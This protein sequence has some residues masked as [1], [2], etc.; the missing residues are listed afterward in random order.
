MP[1]IPDVV[2]LATIQSAQ[3]GNPMRNRVLH[4][5]TD[6]GDYNSIVTSAPTGTWVCKLYDAGSLWQ[7]QAAGMVEML[8]VRRDYVPSVILGSTTS[9]KITVDEAWSIRNNGFVTCRGKVHWNANELSDTYGKISVTLPYPPIQPG[10]VGAFL[11]Y[12]ASLNT[13][14]GGS[15]V[16]Q[17]DGTMTAIASRHP[18]IGTTGSG[19]FDEFHGIADTLDWTVGYRTGTLT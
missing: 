12:D 1:W 11:A 7:K 6:A 2:S 9:G 17:N 19:E 14:Y 8:G 13:Y 15:G 18:P 3:W 16:I 10:V 5:A 4:Q